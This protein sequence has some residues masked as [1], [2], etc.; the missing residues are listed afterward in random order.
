LLC[1]FFL[2]ERKPSSTYREGQVNV[3]TPKNDYPYM[4]MEHI[5]HTPV[6]LVIDGRKTRIEFK[7]L[8]AIF[9]AV[10]RKFS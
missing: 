7:G 5:A 4:G 8:G 9:K 6:M 2:F 3:I 10:I 1:G